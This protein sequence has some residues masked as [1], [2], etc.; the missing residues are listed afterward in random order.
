VVAEG[1]EGQTEAETPGGIATGRLVLRHWRAAD[2]ARL[3]ALSSHPAVA[4]NICTAIA[5]NDGA[6]VIADRFDET[7]LGSAGYSPRLDLPGAN[8][9]SLW[10][11]APYWGRGLATEAAQAL[12]DHAF[13]DSR[14]TVLW[15]SNRVTNTRAR[16]VIEKCG[17]QFRGTGMVRSPT[18]FGAF[19]VERF[20]LDRR[21]WSSLKAW[22]S[23]ATR[24]TEDRHETAA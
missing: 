7:V 15:C 6:F 2:T 22:G 5:S 10:L 1:K 13:S 16:R 20:V 19:P 18:F 17:F 4:E 12:I 24:N 9:V 11:G 14:L 8:E 3:A 23:P 21:N